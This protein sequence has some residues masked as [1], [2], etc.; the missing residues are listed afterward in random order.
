MLIFFAKRRR[1]RWIKSYYQDYDTGRNL[2]RSALYLSAIF[3]LHV[4]AMM[5]LEGIAADDAIWLTATTIVTVGYGDYAAQTPLGRLATITLIYVGGIFVLFHSAADY[6]EFRAQRREK[7][8]RG[9]WRWC[10]HDHI[11]LINSPSFNPLRYFVRLVEEIRHNECF[12]K[13]PVQILT[14]RFDQG[15]PSVLRELGVVHYHDSAHNPEALL[16]VNADRAKAIVILAKEEADERSDGYSFD[17]LHRLSELGTTAT[18]LVEAVSP[19]NEQRLREAG[20]DIVVRPIRFY[21]EIIVRAMIAPGIEQILM[22]MFTIQ[23]DE[24][25]RF[26]LDLVGRP[27]SEIS[28]LLLEHDIGT[29]LGF[30]PRDSDHVHCNPRPEME[31]N[32]RALFVLVREEDHVTDEALRK[33]LRE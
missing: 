18:I 10:M 7:M 13:T 32:A 30:L 1:K 11:L 15:L 26:D 5:A 29:G 2:K 25:K 12:E 19:N 24:C 22:N 9:R 4:L 6:F 23:G 33:A 16:A 3:L 20:A 17:I 21:P 8:A 31:V 14:S 28:R 27:W